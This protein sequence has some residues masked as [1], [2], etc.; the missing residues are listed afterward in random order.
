MLKWYLILDTYECN[1]TYLECIFFTSLDG[2]TLDHLAVDAQSQHVIGYLV[3]V[4]NGR[5]FGLF[6][7]KIEIVQFHRGHCGG[8]NRACCRH[9]DAVTTE[10][11]RSRP[12]YVASKH[13]EIII[14]L[15]TSLKCCAV[16]GI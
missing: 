1:C 11:R 9:A 3:I 5:R 6:V 7:Q 12:T 15:L 16:R 10:Y 8:R 13:N 14:V 4:L 2:K